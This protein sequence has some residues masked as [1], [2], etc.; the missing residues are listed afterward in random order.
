MMRTQSKP[1]FEQRMAQEAQRIREHI[2][3]LPNGSE[4]ELLVRKARQLETAS[5]ISEWLTSTEIKLHQ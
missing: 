4:R 3:S 1:S 5:H 2:K